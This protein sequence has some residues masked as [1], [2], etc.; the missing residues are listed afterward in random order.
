MHPLTPN[1]S[2]LKDEELFSKYQ[3]L[4]NKMSMA[5]KFRNHAMLVQLQM[6]IEDYQ[7]E[8]NLRRQAQLDTKND[9]NNLSSLIKVK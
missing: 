8:I 5:Y 9:K 2:E 7:T 6:L 4:N 3:D 1:L